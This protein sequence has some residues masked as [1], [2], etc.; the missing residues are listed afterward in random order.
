MFLLETGKCPVHLCRCNLSIHWLLTVVLVAHVLKHFLL[1]I[2]SPRKFAGWPTYL[3]PGL[4]LVNDWLTFDRPRSS[5]S[6]TE[7]HRFT[8]YEELT[9]FEVFIFFIFL[10]FRSFRFFMMRSFFLSIFT[11]KALIACSSLFSKTTRKSLKIDPL[12]LQLHCLPKVIERLIKFIYKINMFIS[13]VCKIYSGYKGFEK[14]WDNCI[15]TP[16]C[17]SEM[18]RIWR[19]RSI[20]LLFATNCHSMLLI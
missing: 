19:L 10:S 7:F 1:K 20:C 3:N 4:K 16:S 18:G 17:C 9:H 11:H 14:N 12:I 5:L 13:F 2:V 8:I 6:G 15:D